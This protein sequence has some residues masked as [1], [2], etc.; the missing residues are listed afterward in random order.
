[1]RNYL[2][3]VLVLALS[4]ILMIPTS[5]SEGLTISPNANNTSTATFE[6]G[7]WH[8]KVNKQI[9]IAAD[10]VNNQDKPQT[11]AYL[12][13]IQNQDGVVISLSWLT[14]SLDSSQTLSPAQSWMPTVPGIYTAQIFVWEGIDNPNALSPT[15]SMKI[16]AT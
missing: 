13:Q 14:G 11:F 2:M 6:N 7:V 10:I 15:L 12:V 16:E 5:Y 1:M 4:T 9:Q 8:T 3:I